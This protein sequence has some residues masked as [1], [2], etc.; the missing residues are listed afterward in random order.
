VDDN[1]FERGLLDTMPIYEYRCEACTHE[2]E[3]LQKYSDQP[4]TRCPECA[5]H[6]LRKKVSAAAFRLKGSGWYETDFK[7]GSKKNLASGDKQPESKREGKKPDASGSKT[8]NKQESSGGGSSS[9]KT[10]SPK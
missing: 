10:D 9:T 1:E 7:S 3:V 8:Q 5:Q 2:L 4:L 6:T